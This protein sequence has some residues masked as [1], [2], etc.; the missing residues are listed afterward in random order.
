VQACS[1]CKVLSALVLLLATVAL[2]LFT[3]IANCSMM[4]IHF[5]RPVEIELDAD[6]GQRMNKTS[7]G[8][9]LILERE[10]GTFCSSPN[11]L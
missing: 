9:R 6:L 1:Q 2:L 3:V 4:H 11:V 10:I 5:M 8:E 7:K